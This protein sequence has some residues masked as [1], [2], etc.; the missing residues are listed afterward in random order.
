MKH[1]RRQFIWSVIKFRART[2]PWFQYDF[3]NQMDTSRHV[4][5]EI[6]EKWENVQNPKKTEKLN[7]IDVL[8]SLIN[9]MFK[10]NAFKNTSW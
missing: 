9:F 1:S 7:K 5:I 10:L 4:L 2:I 6:N 8:M 3:P